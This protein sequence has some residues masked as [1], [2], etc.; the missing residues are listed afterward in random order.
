MIAAIRAV[1][2]NDEIPAGILAG[3]FDAMFEGRAEPEQMAALLTGL[4]I[5]GETANDL[6]TAARVMRRHARRLAPR[7]GLIDTCGTGGLSWPSLNTSTAAALVVAACGQQVAKHGNRSTPP[8]TGAADV[9]EALGVN[10]NTTDAEAE[11]CLERAGVTFLFARAHHSAMRHVAPVRAKIGIRTIFNMIG[12]LTNPAGAEYQL[13]GVSADFLVDR[14]AG[15][16]FQLGGKRAWVVHGSGGIDEL[17]ISGPSRVV[18]VT[19]AGLKSFIV[20][21]A[22]AG[23]GTHPISSLKGGSPQQNAQAIRDLLDGRSGPFRDI[24]VLNSAA[25]L[26]IAGRAESLMHGAGMAQAAIDD[27]RAKET[28]RRLIAASH[29]GRA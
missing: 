13:L 28:L 3:A 26:V 18:E 15:A 17:S 4:A 19:P 27:G 11:A 1:A 12:P 22:E 21:P 7:A 24:V 9:L 10:L 6:A 16:L 29:G 5:R 2:D 8:K 23:L 20:E 25:A 14:I